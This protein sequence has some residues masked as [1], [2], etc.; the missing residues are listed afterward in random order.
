MK[1]VYSAILE[2]MK[3]STKYLAWVP[4]LSGCTTSGRDLADAIEMITDAASI[5][6]VTAEDDGDRIPS[7]TPQNALSHEPGCIFTVIQV[8][9]LAYR[10]EIDTRAVRKNVSMPS[11][12]ANLAEKRGINL[13]KVLQNALMKELNEE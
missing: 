7:P 12:M 8:D 3:E 10:A 13:S 2:P 1:Y 9:T 11:W 4:D 6:L 5:W